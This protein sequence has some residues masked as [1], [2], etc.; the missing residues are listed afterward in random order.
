M[1]SQLDDLHQPIVR[2]GAREDH[3]GFPH[4]LPIGVVEFEAVPVPF[5]D[6]GLAVC[7]GGQ[8]SGLKLAGVE[9]EPH[10]PALLSHVA[11]LG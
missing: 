4:R 10:G 6:H 5:V 2:R 9:A 7:L 11:L 8:G 1:V 3:T